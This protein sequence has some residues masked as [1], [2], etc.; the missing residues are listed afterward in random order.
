MVT[1]KQQQDERPTLKQHSRRTKCH[2]GKPVHR[3]VDG[4]LDHQPAKSHSFQVEGREA[5]SLIGRPCHLARSQ[6]P[7]KVK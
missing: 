4:Q 6:H 7:L 5:M 2:R 3:E 1:A